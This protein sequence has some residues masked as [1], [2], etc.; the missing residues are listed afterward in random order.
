MRTAPLRHV[1]E[2][3]TS[4]VDK[5]TRDG[6]LSV[7]LCNY[8]D[9]YRNDK[10]RPGPDH[11]RATATFDEIA[12]FRLEI[13]DSVLTKDSE[14]PND[15]GI[16]A[17]VAD[18]AS[19]FVCGYH[20][21]IARPSPGT[22]P[23]YLTWTLRSRPVLDHFSNHASGISRYGLTTAGLRAAPIPWH[24]E[25]EQRRIA[26]FLDDRVARID[27]IIAARRDQASL[28][29]DHL[30]AALGRLM[31]TLAAQ[32]GLAPLRRFCGGIEQGSSPV[33]EDRPAADGEDGLLKTSAIQAGRFVEEFNKVI[34]PDVV[35]ERFR[36]ADGDVLVT[37]GS[38]SADLVGDAATVRVTGSARLYLSDLTYRVKALS[39]D[40]EF[41]TLAIISPRGRAELGS[42]VRQGTGPAKARGDDILAIPIPNAPPS[43][44]TEAVRAAEDIRADTEAGVNGLTEAV[45]LLSEYKQSLITA[46]VTGEVDVTTAGSGIP[47]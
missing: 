43:Q 8:T 1:A 23:R 17:H 12:R 28:S 14:D 35:N 11:M 24:D 13:G 33:G 10:V 9:V 41:T 36:V 22:H 20:L 31:D 21:A 25:P 2:V 5:Q 42:L 39:I 16:S 4:S 45:R 34:D 15:I 18:T 30:R 46:A 19:D 38:G 47:G 27:Q 7:Q 6:E 29:A 26:D 37:R 32:F 40:P 44:Q 3:R